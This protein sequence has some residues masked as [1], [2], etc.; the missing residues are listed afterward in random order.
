MPCCTG[1]GWGWV[2]GWAWHRGRGR[3]G[4][5]IA[6]APSPVPGR[7]R[8][9]RGDCS[10]CR[11]RRRNTTFSSAPDR[12]A[13]PLP[14]LTSVAQSLSLLEPSVSVPVC[15]PPL[16][17]L[18]AQGLSLAL[19][20]HWACPSLLP[21][22]LSHL[23]RPPRPPPTSS[24]LTHQLSLSPH[25]SCLLVSLCLF[26]FPLHSLP[27]LSPSPFPAACRPIWLAGGGEGRWGWGRGGGKPGLLF[28]FCVTKNLGE[29]PSESGWVTA[30]PAARS[31]PPSSPPSLAPL[32][33]PPPT[34]GLPRSP[35]PSWGGRG[36]RGGGSKLG[37]GLSGALEGSLREEG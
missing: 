3:T 37:R 25:V 2:G 36:E 20:G 15:L 1:L 4:W 30:P 10:H 27:F 28:T 35:H 22:R 19:P 33:L 13:L 29:L 14:S 23:L 16:P 24:S 5:R 12:P 18:C 32:P 21:S 31:P 7:G 17:W 26:C 11:G 9:S 8:L 34:A 6:L